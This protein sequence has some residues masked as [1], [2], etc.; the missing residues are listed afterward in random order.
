MLLPRSPLTQLQ[1]GGR[2]FEKERGLENKKGGGEEFLK[3]G[4]RA[5]KL[6]E[7]GS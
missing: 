2:V 6:R 3:G 7:E 5:G 1:K 4:E